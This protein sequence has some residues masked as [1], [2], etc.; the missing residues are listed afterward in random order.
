MNLTA[1]AC[2]SYWTFLHF[3][4]TAKGSYRRLTLPAKNIVAHEYYNYGTLQQPKIT[5]DLH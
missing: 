3:D 4:T 2:Y 1:N 5:A